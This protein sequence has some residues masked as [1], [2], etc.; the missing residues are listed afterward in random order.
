ML[1]FIKPD[2]VRVILLPVP[3]NVGLQLFHL[4][5]G[6]NG[7]QYLQGNVSPT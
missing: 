5:G 7:I 6:E 3:K 2:S 4:L 1:K